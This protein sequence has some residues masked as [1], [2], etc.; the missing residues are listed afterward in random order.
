MWNL[1]TRL[2]H[3]LMVLAFALAW[4]TYDDSRHLDIHTTSGYTFFGLLLFRLVWIELTNYA[5][6]NSAENKQAEAAW[7]INRS[8]MKN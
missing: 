5:R 7:K 8:V 1:P 2:F 4:A 6:E 3:C